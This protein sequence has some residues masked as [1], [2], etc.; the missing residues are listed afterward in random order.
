M[1]KVVPEYKE[2]AK[3][4]IIEAGTKVFIEKG[5]HKTKMDDIA[6]EL[7]VSKGAIYQYFK[8]KDQLFF[9]VVDFFIQVRKDE[10]MSII[11][12]EEPMRVTSAEFIEMKIARAAQTKSFGLDIFLE[13]A[14]NESLR[15]RMAEVLQNSYDEFLKHSNELKQ[16]GVIKKDADVGT[17]WRGLVA[18]RDGL[19]TS[20]LLG[21]EVSDV[22]A[23]WVKISKM[24]L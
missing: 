4:R 21:A 15:E 10:V 11:L 8:S 20:I 12:S 2:E 3:R 18:M 14:R 9:D 17:I 13:A 23:T 5:Y 24:L 19:I 7:G 1:P 22:T 6:D 16:K